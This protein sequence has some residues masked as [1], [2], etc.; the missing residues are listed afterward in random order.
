MNNQDKEDDFDSERGSP[1]DK[2]G[3]V[4]SEVTKPEYKGIGRNYTTTF[5][6]CNH[7]SSMASDGQD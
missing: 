7:A 2:A 5:A 1:Y 4:L 6:L 3:L